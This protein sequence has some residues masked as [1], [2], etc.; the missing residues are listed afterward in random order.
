MLLE[1]TV[2]NFR[3]FADEQTLSMVASDQRAKNSAVDEAN[4]IAFGEGRRAL[5]SAVVYGANASGKSNLYRAFETMRRLLVAPFKSESGEPLPVEPFRLRTDTR[6]EPCEFEVVLRHEGTQYRYGIE[7]DEERVWA[8]WLL[9]LDDETEAA[10]FE[11]TEQDIALSDDLIA[12]DPIRTLTRRDKPFLAVAAEF[13][14]A[15]AG[16]LITWF[17]AVELLDAGS[18]ATLHWTA[19]Q[20]KERTRFAQPIKGLIRRLDLGIRDIF[21]DDRSPGVKT[22]HDVFEEGAGA[23]VETATFS[24]FDHESG[25]TQKLFALAG[26]LLEVLDRGGLLIVDEFDA[27][28]HPTLTRALLALFHSPEARKKGAQIILFTHDTHLMD[29][30]ALRRDQLWIVQ[31]NRRGESTLYS[32]ASLRGVRNDERFERRYLDG[33]YGGLP[34]PVHLELSIE[35]IADGDEAE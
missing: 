7:L 25:G 13:N 21:V 17:Q 30:E 18:D 14:I 1:F 28:L 4:T 20:I 22:R 5:R 24:L 34:H 26:P 3:S 33:R 16:A 11:R 31:K 27:R 19:S 10:L 23:Q 32:L 2:C 6:D 12:A 35:E 9:R 29:H 8:E 15:L